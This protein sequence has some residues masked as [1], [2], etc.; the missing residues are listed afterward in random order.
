[1]AVLTWSVLVTVAV[2]AGTSGGVVVRV[3]VTGAPMTRL[4]VSGAAGDRCAGRVG[5]RHGDGVDAVGEAGRVERTQGDGHQRASS[6]SSA[7]GDR[8]GG[9]E[10]R[11]PLASVTVY[12]AMTDCGSLTAACTWAE[13]ATWPPGWVNG[14]VALTPATMIDSLRSVSWPGVPRVISVPPRRSR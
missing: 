8:R 14:G 13:T 9:E 5:Q 7:H 3:P 1:M 6:R 10:R 11:S 12:E 2:P 4:P